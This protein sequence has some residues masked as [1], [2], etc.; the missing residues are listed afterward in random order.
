VAAVPHDRPR[1]CIVLF[2]LLTGSVLVLVL[3]EAV[4]VLVIERGAVF[5]LQFAHPLAFHGVVIE[6]RFVHRR[7]FR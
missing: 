5:G 7:C 1:A 3:S 4:L 2:W 6:A